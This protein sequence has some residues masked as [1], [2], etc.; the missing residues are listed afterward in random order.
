MKKIYTTAILV[1]TLG[2]F[3]KLNAQNLSQLSNFYYHQSVF[4]PAAAGMYKTEVNFGA[5][6]S[7]QWTGIEGAPV[8]STLWGDYKLKNQKSVIGFN[9]NR[10]T[11]GVTKTTDYAVNYTQIIRLNNRFN[12]AMG[13]RAG[14]SS[15]QYGQL[16][17]KKIWDDNDAFEVNPTMNKTNPL[18]GAGIRISDEKMYIGF[19]SPDLIAKSKNNVYN[20]EGESN[21]ILI[22]HGGYRFRLSEAYNLRANMLVRSQPNTDL[23]ADLNAVFEIRDYFWAG[24]TYSTSKFHS[25]VVGT[26]ISSTLRASYAFQFALSKDVPKSFYSHEIGLILNLDILKK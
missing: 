5:I 10:N 22:L 11:Y 1:L 14:A 8:Y 2:I 16:D 19:S 23:R 20:K 18:V 24:A 12:M 9:I 26:N 6:T 25:I 15:T 17:H 3:A 7:L 21:R 4:N 13:V